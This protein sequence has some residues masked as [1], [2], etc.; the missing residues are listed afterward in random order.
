MRVT[1]P[2]L[3]RGHTCTFFGGK[4]GFRHRK[5][6]R[7]KPPLSRIRFGGTCMVMALEF[8]VLLLHELWCCLV[9]VWY[10]VFIL[11]FF[12]NELYVLEISQTTL[13]R[14]EWIVGEGIRLPTHGP[15]SRTISNSL[16]LSPS[17]ASTRV[18]SAAA[19]SQH[20]TSRDLTLDRSSKKHT[21]TP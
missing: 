8:D 5:K 13:H 18:C 9:A 6:M 19:C 17:N 21:V 16:L 14:Y 1:F 7:A 12:A 20:R 4:F 11:F 2:D 3:G 10:S 15:R